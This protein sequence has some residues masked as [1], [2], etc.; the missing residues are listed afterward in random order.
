MSDLHS[1]STFTSVSKVG[2]NRAL[3]VSA[4]DIS[5][6]FRAEIDSIH[7]FVVKWKAASLWTGMLSALQD[8]FVNSWRLQ[9]HG[10]GLT[11]TARPP[12]PPKLILMSDELLE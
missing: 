9:T 12:G 8:K 4:G 3:V 6:H 1:P 11:V 2:E 5:C 7:T 10:V